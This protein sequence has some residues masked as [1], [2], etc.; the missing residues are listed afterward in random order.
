MQLYRRIKSRVILR[1]ERRAELRQ[2][3]AKQH[4]VVR[5]NLSQERREEMFQQNAQQH[6][7]AREHFPQ[8]RGEEMLQQDASIVIIN[9]YN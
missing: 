4:R 9:C 8:E 6:R 2:Q 1:Q 7:A 3:N 5:D